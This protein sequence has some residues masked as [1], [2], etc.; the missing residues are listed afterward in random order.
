MHP[1]QSDK[2]Q[3]PTALNRLHQQVDAVL[4]VNVVYGFGVM[5][6]RELHPRVRIVIW[7]DESTQH[8]EAVELVVDVEDGGIGVVAKTKYL[9]LEAG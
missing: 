5:R 6:L 1:V 3:I 9:V 8:I 4:H 2:V 7:V